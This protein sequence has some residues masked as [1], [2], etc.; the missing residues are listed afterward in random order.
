VAARG[1]LAVL[2]TGITIAVAALPAWGQNT[3]YYDLTPTERAAVGQLAADSG[4]TFPLIDSW[5]QGIPL[6]YYTFGREEL[7]AQ[8]LYRVRGGGDILTSVPGMAHY[9]SIRVVYDVRLADG[10]DPQTV[11]SHTEIEDLARRGLARIVGTGRMLNLPVVP[12]GSTLER[13]P[14][15][16]PLRPAW[17]KG[18]PVFYVDFGATRAEAIPQVLF[19]TGLDDQGAPAR[20]PDQPSNVSHVPPDPAYRDLWD[21]WLATVGPGFAAGTYRDM[22]R[23]FADRNVGTYAL[24]HAGFVVNCPVVYVNGT[25]APR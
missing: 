25:A 21:M 13:D 4:L 1:V 14:D 15:H 16:R 24:V 9:T 11:R 20:V 8:S 19:I 7:G 3:G 6:Q 2:G 22:R 5:Y 10:T 17:Y 23:A 18:E 12:P